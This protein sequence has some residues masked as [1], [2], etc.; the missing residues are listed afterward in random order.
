MPGLNGQVLGTITVFQD[1]TTFK[2][3][4]EMKSDFVHMVSHELRSPLAS[5]KQLLTVVLDGLA[6]ELMDKQKDLLSRS[7]VEDSGPA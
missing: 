5:I 1:I 7:Q 6:G 4:D 3:L 2:Q